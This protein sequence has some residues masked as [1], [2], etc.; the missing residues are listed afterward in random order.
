MTQDRSTVRRVRGITGSMQ[1][2]RVLSDFLSSNKLKKNNTKTNT[3][4][5]PENSIPETEGQTP[6]GPLHKHCHCRGVPDA[7]GN[8]GVFCA[9]SDRYETPVNEGKENS[10][11]LAM[12]IHHIGKTQE[13]LHL[14]YFGKWRTLNFKH[15]A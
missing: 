12:F 5:S 7:F 9:M 10:R 4:P 13:S 1:G 6:L 14:H 2:D 8:G 15:T 3:V 11:K